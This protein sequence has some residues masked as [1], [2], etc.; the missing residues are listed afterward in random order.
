MSRNTSLL[1]TVRLLTNNVCIS[2]IIESSWV[3]HQ[4]PGRKS[5]C[6]DVFVTLRVIE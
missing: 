5:D 1:S 3:I 4:S 6:E 2:C